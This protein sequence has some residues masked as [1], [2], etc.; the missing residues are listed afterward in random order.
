MWEPPEAGVRYTEDHEFRLVASPSATGSRK[1]DSGGTNTRMKLALD[2]VN[3]SV[4][5]TIVDITKMA[6][7]LG[8]T[9]KDATVLGGGQKSEAK[10]N[11]FKE[12]FAKYWEVDTSQ[13][14]K[15]KEW[16]LNAL[17]DPLYLPFW[18]STEFRQFWIQIYKQDSVHIDWERMMIWVQPFLRNAIALMPHASILKSELEP[19][20]DRVIDV[21]SIDVT[22][23]IDGGGAWL[24]VVGEVADWHYN[25]QGTADFLKNVSYFGAQVADTIYSEIFAQAG[26][27]PPHFKVV[28]NGTYRVLVKR[29]PVSLQMVCSKNAW[30]WMNNQLGDNKLGDI[31][32]IA[33]GVMWHRDM[34]HSM[35]CL[36]I[37]V[38]GEAIHYEVSGKGGRMAD[39]AGTPAQRYHYYIYNNLFKWRPK[40]SLALS[41]SQ[42]RVTVA[43][44]TKVISEDVK[45]N[46]AIT[47]QDIHDMLTAETAFHKQLVSEGQ[48]AIMGAPASAATDVKTPCG[49]GRMSDTAR[50]VSP[51]RVENIHKVPS[52]VKSQQQIQKEVL[53]LR[54]TDF[55]TEGPVTMTEVALYTVTSEHSGETWADNR[56][57]G[58]LQPLHSIDTAI[59]KD[60][61]GFSLLV[62]GVRQDKVNRVAAKGVDIDNDDAIKEAVAA[63]VQSRTPITSAGMLWATQ[64]MWQ[65][66]EY[67]MRNKPGYWNE[68][69]G[70]PPQFDKPV[71]FTPPESEMA[72]PVTSGSVGIV[73]GEGQMS[74]AGDDAESTASHSESVTSHFRGSLPSNDDSA[75][76]AAKQALEEEESEEFADAEELALVEA[77]LLLMSSAPISAEATVPST[78]TEEQVAALST[79][80]SRVRLKRELVDRAVAATGA[81]RESRARLGLTQG[82][83]F[84]SDLEESPGGRTLATALKN[85]FG[86][87]TQ[88]LEGIFKYQASD[89]DTDLAEWYDAAEVEASSSSS[90]QP[91][92]G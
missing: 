51:P 49:E 90:K 29:Y 55:R 45:D 48:L 32:E 74:D 40:K 69:E 52:F 10:D 85:S 50:T 25:N 64:A 36:M 91:T 39:V 21:S 88:G 75:I 84:R 82:Q 19:D 87:L 23:Q 67:R 86:F 54:F 13:K 76:L 53:D 80:E 77:D 59:A 11:F 60:K 81:I 6:E 34:P 42:E 62:K 47:V 1:R 31:F 5:D 33:M 70:G 68:K 43:R 89:E 9:E 28:I 3:D 15:A 46:N 71:D 35:S 27:P 66:Q 22:T 17:E 37:Q 14:A 63:A 24:K 79:E 20:P 26:E 57:V 61:R 38:F 8:I 7:A 4:K 58:E 44:E 78:P 30:Y 56:A 73:T 72:Q 41:L 2:E 16:D 92:V 65:A 83:L 12:I 18:H